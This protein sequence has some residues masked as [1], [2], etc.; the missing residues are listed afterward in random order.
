MFPNQDTL[1]LLQTAGKLERLRMYLRWEAAIESLSQQLE[2]ILGGKEVDFTAAV[3][4]FQQLRSLCT[5]LS[6][7]T[8]TNLVRFTRETLLFWYDLLIKALEVNFTEALKAVQW[9]M[10]SVKLSSEPQPEDY[11]KFQEVFVHILKMEL[12]T[13]LLPRPDAHGMAL[14]IELMLQPLR[15]RFLFHFVARNKT[16]RP[17]KPEWYFTQV[18][19]W[20]SSHLKFMERYVQPLLTEG[21]KPAQEQLTLGLERLAA[22]KLESS[23]EELAA[24]DLLLSHAIEEALAF[25]GELSHLTIASSLTM[26]VL[27]TNFPAW[28]RLE[29]QSALGRMDKLLS[30]PSA[31]SQCYPDERVD[32]FKVPQCAEHFMEL[33]SSLTDRCRLLTQPKLRLAFLDLQLELLDDFRIRLHQLAGTDQADTFYAILNAVNYIINSLKEWSTQPHF[34]VL[35]HHKLHP[36][37]EDNLSLNLEEEDS[38]AFSSTLQLYEH[39]LQDLLKVLNEKIF[40]DIKAKSR[41]YRKEK[42]FCLPVPTEPSGSIYQMLSVLRSYLHKLEECLCRELFST[43]WQQ[44][45]S[46]LDNFLYE[47]VVLQSQFSSGGA[48]QLQLDIHR[49]VVPLLASYTSFPH[50]HLRRSCEAVL[51]LNLSVG[52]ARLLRETLLLPPDS[53]AALEEQ[54]VFTLGREDALLVLAQRLDL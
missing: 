30:A 10:V 9:P 46:D 24:D 29:H 8:C 7:S 53:K 5:I 27:S 51:L 18:L 19:T 52:L 15:K 23:W 45:A 37:E 40:L 54:K 44:A 2:V 43:V 31:W 3:D 17:D 22:S 33:L 47:E 6:T 14:P 4:L 48:Q 39:M 21:S 16:N 49:T 32:E 20:I 36:A 13:D 50:S 25:A 12:S 34:V 41:P 35:H 38:T 28:R 11:Q 42:W 1:E 26:E